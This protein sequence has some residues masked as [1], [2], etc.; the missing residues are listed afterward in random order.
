M[1]VPEVKVD[2]LDQNPAARKL[3]QWIRL[4]IK[5][6]GLSDPS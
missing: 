6:M 3:D 5:F 2:S 1:L 4:Y